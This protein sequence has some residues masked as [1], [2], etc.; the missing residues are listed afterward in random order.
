MIPTDAHAMLAAALKDLHADLGVLC[1]GLHGRGPSLESLRCLSPRLC[2][3]F[4]ATR[5]AL[6]IILPEAG[7]LDPC[8]TP[9]QTPIRPLCLSTD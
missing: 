4:N 8:C 2:H 3:S 9:R 1:R 7:I 6:A 5:A